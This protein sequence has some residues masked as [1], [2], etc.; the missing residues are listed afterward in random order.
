VQ[1][2]AT[3]STTNATTDATNTDD[4]TQPEPQAATATNNE[5]QCS[6][7]DPKTYYETDGL[8]SFDLS[9]L[10]L[11]FDSELIFPS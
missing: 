9:Q 2:T 10:A 1:Q 3:M 5:N 7:F 11:N 8:P 6:V 4:V